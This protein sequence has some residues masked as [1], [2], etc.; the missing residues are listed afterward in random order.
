MKNAP[1][2]I[3]RVVV[4]TPL[5]LRGRGGIDR[6]NDA[7]FQTI[8]EHPEFGIS[9]MRLVTRGKGGLFSAQIV[10]ASALFHLF[11]A[12]LLRKMDLLHIH[13]SD[14][15]SCYRKTF[16][17]YLA[18]MLGIPYVVHLHGAIFF[19]YWS[20]APFWVARSIDNLFRCS[21]GIIVLG[22]YWAEGITNRLPDV[23]DKI[24]VLP[25]ATGASASERV[26]SHDG[27][28]RITFLGQ[29]GQRK[30]TADLIAALRL[31]AERTDWMATIAGDGSVDESRA[32]VRRAMMG[33]RI[34]IPGWLS[35]DEINDLLCQTD[36]LVL[37]SYSENLPMVILEGFAHGVTVISTPVGAIPEVIENGRNGLLVPV[38]DIPALANALRFA[39]SDPTLR[40][41]LGD[42]ARRDHATW[43][44]IT[45]YVGRLAE[46]WKKA[47]RGVLRVATKEQSAK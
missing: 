31:L 41:R 11:F 26:T 8:A 5:G 23:T 21:R 10:F 7:V 20:K 40:R 46:Q 38:G 29:L 30:G 18:Q 43:Y 2:N 14:R 16:L 28:V 15:G 13:L 44:E 47:F 42:A 35:S 33:S 45:S 39:I 19:E 32:S 36:I 6:L 4:A 12:R 17:G 22:Q 9:T 27:V 37:P 25:N 24:F 1:D 3:L 34:N